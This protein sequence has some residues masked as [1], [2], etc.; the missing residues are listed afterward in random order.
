MLKEIEENRLREEKLKAIK[1]EI[2]RIVAMPIT[3]QQHLEQISQNY[4]WLTESKD[5][6]DR[7]ND[8]MQSFLNCK[9]K[10]TRNRLKHTFDVLGLSGDIASKSKNFIFWLALTLALGHDLGHWPF[11]HDTQ[12]YLQEV[13]DDS[14]LN[15]GKMGARVLK[16]KGLDI[17][18]WVEFGIS[19]HS[20]GDL[21]INVE[22]D[23][24]D[25]I[26][27]FVLTCILVAIADD[28]ACSITD[29][30]DLLK[31]LRKRAPKK[32]RR[33]FNIA[34]RLAGSNIQ[35][36]L[37]G[38]ISEEMIE[39]AQTQLFSAF[40]NDIVKSSEGKKGV[41]MSVRM[42]RAFRI[43]KSYFYNVY[44]QTQRVKTQRRKVVEKVAVVFTEACSIIRNQDFER[45][46]LGR[47]I[48]DFLASVNYYKEQDITVKQIIIDFLAGKNEKKIV[49][50]FRNVKRRIN[51]KLK[52]AA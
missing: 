14:T 2:G 17:N 26:L 1:E 11:T 43:L 23:Y 25:E 30:G 24:Q 47:D 45:T 52:M 44:L 8:V 18:P 3:W 34:L 49:N 41:F 38:H 13:T 9:R 16:L 10:S 32:A 29:M 6:I 39:R 20:D 4:V 28:I 50:Y 36:P 22:L 35:V 33:V 51:Y 19:H 42:F 40:A 5:L 31:E 48:K 27:E 7:L 46:K 21:F 37:K 12:R 15:H